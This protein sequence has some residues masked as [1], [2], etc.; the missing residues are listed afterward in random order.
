M[1]GRKGRGGGGGG[2]WDESESVRENDDP[3]PKFP[4]LAVICA[5]ELV[6]GAPGVAPTTDE[7]DVALTA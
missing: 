2:K 4:A 6:V 1:G 5:E 7:D 3:G